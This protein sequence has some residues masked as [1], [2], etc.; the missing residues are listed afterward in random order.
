MLL[1][2][3]AN[4]NTGFDANMVR[5]DT[6]LP[7]YAQ[8]RHTFDDVMAAGLAVGGTITGE[9]GVGLLKRSWLGTELGPRVTALQVGIKRIFDPEGILNPGKVW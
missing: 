2:E 8:H 3:P 7:V 9:H 4:T 5:A 1:V 6:P